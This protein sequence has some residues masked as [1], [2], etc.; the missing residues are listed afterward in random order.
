MEATNRQAGTSAAT[1]LQSAQFTCMLPGKD[2]NRAR[3]NY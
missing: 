3:R 2:M 1:V